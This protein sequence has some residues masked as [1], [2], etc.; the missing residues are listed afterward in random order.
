MYFSE[1][2]KLSFEPPFSYD[3]RFYWGYNTRGKIEKIVLQIKESTILL[4][5]FK[6]SS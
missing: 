4:I 5:C 2:D 6:W 1:V 3:W